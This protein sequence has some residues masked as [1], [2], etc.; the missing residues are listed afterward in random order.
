MH[1]KDG[2]RRGAARLRNRET[3]HADLSITKEHLIFQKLD[4]LRNCI[5]FGGY[6]F[7]WLMVKKNKEHT[8]GS[9]RNCCLFK[10]CLINHPKIWGSPVPKLHLSVFFPLVPLPQPLWC[11]RNSSLYEKQAAALELW[12]QGIVLVW[13][14]KLSAQ[15]PLCGRSDQ[16]KQ[17][18]ALPER[19]GSQALTFKYELW[20]RWF[21]SVW[22]N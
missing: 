3:L 11:V 15:S 20:W 8:E 16:I 7:S 18:M 14:I 17:E 2:C 19:H 13:N 9:P 5:N 22:W 10:H 4:Q 6:E 21:Q 12:P 1:I